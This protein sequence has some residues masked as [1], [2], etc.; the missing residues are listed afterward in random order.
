MEFG[1]TELISLILIIQ[2]V[3]IAGSYL[4]AWISKLAGNKTGLMLQLGIWLL[5]CIAAFFI[6]D[7][8]SFYLLAG[9]V[10]MVFGGIQSLSRAT[11]AMLVADQTRSAT[12][13]FSFYDV[14]EKAAIVLGTFA[15]GLVAEWTGSMRNSTLVLAV[16][17]LLGLAMLGTVSLKR[18]VH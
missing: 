12:S 15:F 5:I 6:K 7:K 1:T 17:F 14:L 11:Y 8:I 3:A 9:L 13:F 10:G 4:F 2:L 16:F 18:K